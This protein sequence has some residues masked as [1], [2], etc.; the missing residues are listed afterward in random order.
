MCGVYGISYSNREVVEKMINSCGH[1]GPDGQDIYVDDKVTIGHNLLSITDDPKQSLQ[2]WKTPKGNVLSYNGEIFNYHELCAKYKDKFTPRTNCDTELLAWGLDIFGY[3]FV[4]E[5]DSQHAFV[6]YDIEKQELMLST[7]H[8]SIKPLYYSLKNNDIM[9]SSEIKNMLDNVKHSNIISKEG[10][11]CYQWCGMNVLDQTMFNGIKKLTP[12]ETLIYDLHN[13]KIKSRLYQRIIPK[14]NHRFDPDEFRQQVQNTVKMHSIG[15]RNFG[16]FLSGGLDSSI[17]AYEMNKINPSTKTF[18]N[19]FLVNDNVEIDKGYNSDANVA[20]MLAKQENFNHTEVIVTPD[21]LIDFWGRSVESNEECNLNPTN[22]AYWYTNNYMKQCGITITMAGDLGDELLTGYHKHLNFLTK[23]KVKT[24]QQFLNFYENLNT[25]SPFKMPKDYPVEQI[26]K[27][28]KKLYVDPLWNDKDP[29][30]SYMAIECLTSVN[31]DFLRR[32]DKFGMANS[33]EGRFPFTTK[34]FMN[35]C[36]SIHSSEKLNVKTGELKLPS[37]IAYQNILPKPLLTKVKTGWTAPF[38]HWLSN[39]E[40]LKQ[41]FQKSVKQKVDKRS[42][43]K[44]YK[45]MFRKW[46][47]NDWKH[48][49]NIV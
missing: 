34:T 49:Y 43:A 26:I 47:F 15:I 20:S 5:I 28:F 31:Y 8:L 12:G 2:P 40:K 29:L 21:T 45:K 42:G 35:Y 27:K 44:T 25:A 33:L 37:K 38:G 48:K 16:I 9:F 17:I 1:R 3:K 23:D 39:N 32:N 22:F 11:A 36:F 7:D 30:G 46:M 18:T 4:E 41:F 14:L 24:S 13:K 19:R 6:L 10:L